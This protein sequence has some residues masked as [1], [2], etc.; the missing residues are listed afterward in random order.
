MA[1][2]ALLQFTQGTNVGAQG[3]ALVVTAGTPVVIR[4]SNNISTQSYRLELCYAP[5]GSTYAFTP[6][7][8]APTILAQSNGAPSFS[9]TPDVAG[10]YRFRLTVWNGFGY[11]GQPDVDIRNIGIVFANGLIAPSY[12][13]F[14]DPLPLPGT[15]LPGAKPGELNFG[16]QPYGWQGDGDPSRPLLYQAL[17]AIGSGGG[18]GSV[19]VTEPLAGDGTSDSPLSLS[20]GGISHSL[21]GGLSG[22]DHT[23]YLRTDG[24][25]LAT[26][27]MG[28]DG[29]RITGVGDPTDGSDATNRAYVAAFVQAWVEADY[30]ADTPLG[31][32]YAGEVTVGGVTTS[33]SLLLLTAEADASNNGLWLTGPLDW[34]RPSVFAAGSHAAARYLFIKGDMYAGTGWVCTAA[35]GMDVI[36]VNELHWLQFAPGGVPIGS[37]PNTVYTSNGEHNS[38]SSDIQVASLTITNGYG[39]ALNSPGGS[40]TVTVQGNDV[41]VLT[42]YSALLSAMNLTQFSSYFSGAPSTSQVEH[43]AF[44]GATVLSPVSIEA[45]QQTTAVSSLAYVD[46][47]IQHCTQHTQI[48]VAGSASSFTISPFEIASGIAYAGTVR[49][50]RA[51]FATGTGADHFQHYAAVTLGFNCSYLDGIQLGSMANDQT[52]PVAS[53]F[54]RMQPGGNTWDAHVLRQVAASSPYSAWSS[55]ITSG[56]PALTL[57]FYELGVVSVFDFYWEFS[58]ITMP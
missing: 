42:K 27:T 31:P 49:I 56:V 15:V 1:I 4:N 52:T 38:W 5:P 41:L 16:G 33:L 48:R 50:T 22:D 34:V 13:K 39:G 21:L 11:T 44:Q 24:M 7:T 45:R 46:H 53:D 26:G 2:S 47:P 36:G 18:G 19:S 43:A 54:V 9:F 6:G 37:G 30:L 40:L 58:A 20:I 29:N 25:R 17:Q 3:C 23:A 51:S 55:T 32:T 8:T 10:C 35:A 12:Q 14:P 57:T 28:M